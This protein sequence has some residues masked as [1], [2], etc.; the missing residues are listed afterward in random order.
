MKQAIII[1]LAVYVIVYL[2]IKI[3]NKPNYEFF[4]AD[5]QI[6]SEPNN[7]SAKF[8]NNGLNVSWNPPHR[9]ANLSK[10][11]IIIRDSFGKNPRNIKINANNLNSN[12]Y[13]IKK[14]VISLDKKKQYQVSMKAL[15]GNLGSKESKSV[16]I[17]TSNNNIELGKGTINSLDIDSQ[18]FTNQEAEQNIQNREISS[19]KKRVDSLRNDIVILK[20]KEKEENQSIYNKVDMDDTISQIPS[21]VRDR[22]GLNLPGEIDFNFTIDPTL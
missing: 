21:A 20:N 14:N 22:Y 13:F 10:Y 8:L 9:R 7:I 16:I 18:R 6:P 1:I 5:N 12:K 3:Y 2:C 11:I 15:N 17:N 4:L 19:L